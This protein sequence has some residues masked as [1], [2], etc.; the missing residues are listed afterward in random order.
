MPYASA[1]NIPDAYLKA[2]GILKVNSNSADHLV[3]E[4]SNPLKEDAPHVEELDFVSE[5]EKIIEIEPYNEFHRGYESIKFNAMSGVDWIRNRI[6]CLC[7]PVDTL[8]HDAIELDNYRKKLTRIHDQKKCGYLVGE[9]YKIRATNY[10]CYQGTLY[11]ATKNPINQLAVII[12]KLAKD[13][14]A[15]NQHSFVYSIISI[16]DPLKENLG[17]IGDKRTVNI[18]QFPCL[19]SLDFKLTNDKVNLCALWRHQ[20]FDIKAYGN[21]ISLAVL[22]KTVCDLTNDLRKRFLGRMKGEVSPGKITSIAC[23]ADFKDTSQ[24]KKVYSLVTNSHT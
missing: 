23:R 13:V 15:H 10:G 19:T 21:W 11:S 7:P 2:L 3:V 8:R 18:G 4:I 14:P 16:H 6:D 22:L 24:M 5:Y 1:T 20:F 9:S 17:L 12:Y